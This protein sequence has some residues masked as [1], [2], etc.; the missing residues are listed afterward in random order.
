MEKYEI[1]QKSL[2]N[3]EK[4]LDQFIVTILKSGIQGN[5]VKSYLYPDEKT[6]FTL[7]ME[8]PSKTIRII[9]MQVMAS[10]YS[11]PN[12]ISSFLPDD[13]KVLS[14][15]YGIPKEEIEEIIRKE[16]QILGRLRKV[17]DNC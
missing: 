11:W 14:G 1:D 5:I 10:V 12:Q 8:E 9:D 13:V 15:K 4:G 3:Y 6:V 2:E 16:R 7:K 17:S